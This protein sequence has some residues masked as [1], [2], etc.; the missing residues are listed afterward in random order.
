MA[1]TTIVFGQVSTGAEDV[2][3]EL[4][5]GTEVDAGT[6]T[7]DGFDPRFYVE[8]VPRAVEAVRLAP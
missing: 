4:S 5:D 1:D 6:V 8:V 2:T 7:E 3:V